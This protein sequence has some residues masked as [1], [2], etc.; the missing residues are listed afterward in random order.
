MP[1]K[2]HGQRN[3][4]GYSPW[5]RKESD[6]TEL[7]TLCTAEVV[8]KPGG[9]PGRETGIYM[10]KRLSMRGAPGRGETGNPED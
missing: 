2:F 10:Y 5:G 1:G 6:R 7:L 4:E 8:S 9:G 3:L